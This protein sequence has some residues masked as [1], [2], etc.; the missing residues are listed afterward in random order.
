MKSPRYSISGLMAMV[1]ILALDFGAVRALLGGPLFVP[2]LSDLLIYGALPMANILAIGSIY[3]LKSRLD[4]RGGRPAL[5]GFVIF[6]MAALLL[7]LGCSL[8]ATHM[9]H[10]G[11]GAVLRAMGLYPGP[12]FLAGAVALLLLPQLALALLGG[13]LGRT[14]KV[15][16]KIVIERRSLFETEPGP[17]PERL[18]FADGVSP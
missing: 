14:Y 1:L 10:E 4:H 12:I 17:D 2:D 13:W 8:L 15:R 5:A 18:L 11:V 16:L 3:L 6:G 9:I 7:Y